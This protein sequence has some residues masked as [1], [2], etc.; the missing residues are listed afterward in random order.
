MDLGWALVH[1]AD[2]LG[3]HA[4]VV[5]VDL[6]ASLLFLV[7]AFAGADDA[8]EGRVRVDFGLH[9]EHL[10]LMVFVVLMQPG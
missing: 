5:A 8:A 4:L 2:D 6:V 1:D 3:E 9:A 7:G 10:V